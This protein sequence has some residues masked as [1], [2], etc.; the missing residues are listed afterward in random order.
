MSYHTDSADAGLP[1]PSTLNAWAS[2]TIEELE[3]TSKMVVG[4]DEEYEE[5]TQDQMDAFHWATLAKTL[6]DVGVTITPEE[7]SQLPHDVVL[8]ETIRARLK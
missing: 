3:N 4:P 7:L 6:H 1:D 8:S 5:Y 2:V